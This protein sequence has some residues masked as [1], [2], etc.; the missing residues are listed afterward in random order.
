VKQESQGEKGG[1]TEKT[2]R[3]MEIKIE[4]YLNREQILC[5]TYPLLGSPF[6]HWSRA[7]PCPAFSFIYPHIHSTY[8]SP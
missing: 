2:A 4:Q 7:L 6:S 8:S 3:Y 5:C 1:L